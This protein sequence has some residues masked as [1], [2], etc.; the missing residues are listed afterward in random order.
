MYNIYIVRR[1][2]IYLTAEQGAQLELRSRATG[3]TISELIRAAIDA[4]YGGA[5]DMTVADK[6][7]IARS[8]AG[9][10]AHMTE[11]GADYVERVRGAGRLA[12]L[13]RHD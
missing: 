4:E 10:W 3:Q 13:H 8:A 2:Q 5:R 11:S 6:V 1:T 12:K 7:R 9:A